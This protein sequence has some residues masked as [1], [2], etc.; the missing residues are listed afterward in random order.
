MIL[1]CPQCSTRFLVADHLIPPEGR[2]VKCGACKHDWHVSPEDN[3]NAAPQTVDSANFAAAVEQEMAS[4]SPEAEIGEPQ[5]PAPPPQ[6]PAVQSKKLPPHILKIAAG[7]LLV[8]WLSS[9]L[10]ANFYRWQHWPVLSSIYGVLGVVP[11][12]GL[13]FE[14]VQLTPE[15]QGQRTRYLLTGAVVNEGTESRTIPLVHVVLLRKDGSEVWSREYEVNKTVKAGGEYP[16]RI[17]N[18]ETS[19][20]NQVDRIIVDLGNSMQLTFR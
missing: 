12:D 4:P 7:V 8:V 13:R 9:A 20:A 14:N 15:K 16:F 1:Q 10:Y 5:P 17:S 6:L 18:V 2:T 3:A 19:F 11:T